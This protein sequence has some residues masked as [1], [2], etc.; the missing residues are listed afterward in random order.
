M[1]QLSGCTTQLTGSGWTN[2]S[3]E[4]LDSFAFERS[5]W[6]VGV[7]TYG[8]VTVVDIRKGRV[9]D[10]TREGLS[11]YVPSDYA[12]RY[13]RWEDVLGDYPRYVVQA[14]ECLMSESETILKKLHLNT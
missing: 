8:L 6:R 1:N 14:V 3:S 5:K 13:E 11:G 4:R 10:Y 9:R 7:T 2:I 12:W